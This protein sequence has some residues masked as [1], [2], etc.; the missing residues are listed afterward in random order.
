[1][2]IRRVC[3]TKTFSQSFYGPMRTGQPPRNLSFA[4]TLASKS[5]IALN[6]SS[7]LSCGILL[8]KKE[9]ERQTGLKKTFLVNLFIVST[10]LNKNSK[11]D[12]ICARK[13]SAAQTTHTR[14]MKIGSSRKWDASWTCTT[15]VNHS[16]VQMC[17]VFGCCFFV[18]CFLFC[19]FVFLEGGSKPFRQVD[20]YFSLIVKREIF[21]SFFSVHFLFTLFL[22]FI[23]LT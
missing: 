23:L 2:F 10:W 1:M 7:R 5:L 19:M 14:F 16:L 3:E 21:F 11:L 6:L 17:G 20:T 13:K 9:K 15:T 22:G 12:T 8:R 4:E 18:F